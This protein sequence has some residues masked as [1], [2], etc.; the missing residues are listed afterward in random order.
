MRLDNYLTI[1]RRWILVLL[2]V[3]AL[4]AGLAFGVSKLQTPL[5]EASL[6]LWVSQSSTATGQQYADI[7]AAERLA[8]TYGALITK[9][10]VLLETIKELQLDMT[11]E[12]LSSRIAV[13]LVR[14][15]QLLEVTA[16][17]T[18]PALA[19]TIVNKLAEVF[20]KQ[21]IEMQKQTFN[22]ATQKLSGQVSQLEGQI[23][24]A[25][26]QLATLK[27]VKQPTD[28]QRVEIERLNTTL[29][30]YQVAYSSVLKSLEDIRLSEANSLNNVSVAEQAA[31]PQE[32]VLPRTTLNMVLG[33]VLGL[34][35]AG[36]LG[37]V[38]L[39]GGK[40]SRS[41]NKK[42]KDDL[43]APVAGLVSM[44]SVN[45]SAAEAYRLLRA[46]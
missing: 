22:E 42:K 4:V 8:K 40:R 21:N 17:N 32:P 41:K 35:L 10:P 7:L 37:V 45:S 1:I 28:A 39:I 6:T 9:R 34:V 26:G 15:T 25:Q 11:P 12:E 20:E 33:L 46:N 14:D 27:A 43:S 38:E 13:K 3:P 24:D 23:K 36:G 2:A 16:R 29:S 44:T 5:Y 31:V 30:Q 18:D 19:A